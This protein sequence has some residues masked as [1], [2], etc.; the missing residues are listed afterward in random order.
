[1]S[2]LPPELWLAI[3]E[4]L[5]E[6]ELLIAGRVCQTWQKWAFD[7][8][9]R[10]HPIRLPEIVSLLEPPRR[11]TKKG[12]RESFHSSISSSYRPSQDILTRFFDITARITTIVVD[13][14]YVSDGAVSLLESLAASSP[15]KVLFP[16]LRCVEHI[17]AASHDV[18]KIITGSQ[19]KR[20]IIRPHKGIDGIPDIF[21][22]LQH[23]QNL[24]DVTA[25]GSAFTFNETQ[26]V[27]WP[28]RLRRLHFS[29][30]WTLQSWK[31]LVER[32]VVLQHAKIGC[33]QVHPGEWRQPTSAEENAQPTIIAPNLGT[34]DLDDIR[35][36]RRVLLMLRR[37]EMPEL[38][39][40]SFKLGEDALRQDTEDEVDDALRMLGEKS[41]KLG[42]LRVETYVPLETDLLS[43]FRWL[44]T[45][46]ISNQAGE[47][48]SWPW[49]YWDEDIEII[50]QSMPRLAH[51]RLLGLT[52]REP[53][54]TMMALDSL[55]IHCK[56][57][58]TLS[59]GINATGSHFPHDVFTPFG[60]TLTSMT[61]SPLRIPTSD[62]SLLARNLAVRMPGVDK[63]QGRIMGLDGRRAF[64]WDD[65][66]K[67]IE[68]T[69]EKL[70]RGGRRT[71]E[72]RQRRE[73]K[74]ATDVWE[75][76]NHAFQGGFEF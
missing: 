43:K 72:V 62:A 66:L 21:H 32:C 59:I 24:E 6:V 12:L 45:L 61:F 74:R 50:A 25:L 75:M 15:S 13:L 23:H 36:S 19:L 10:S 33:D 3:L 48:C 5:G 1:M 68:D 38:T 58:H 65:G 27:P 11:R 44:E 54:P 67:I 26:P 42:R 16:A 64:Y 76:T 7:T 51:L 29:A 14:E 20:I 49:V 39:E 41:P 2:A 71:S 53:G 34:L 18:N 52:E 63:F 69:V 55:A 57:L 28:L 35:H 40:L 46:H 22:E 70:R 60:K 9:W 30:G 47:A 8:R 4:C 31:E 56:R 37:T 17:G 73:S